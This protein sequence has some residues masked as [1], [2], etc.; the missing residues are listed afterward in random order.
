MMA[1]FVYTDVGA[2]PSALVAVSTEITAISAGPI[3]MPFAATW[4]WPAGAVRWIGV[5]A[6]TEL[7]TQG[8]IA[9][10]VANGIKF[11][12]DT[13]SDGPSDP[14]G[15]APSSANLE[16]VIWAEGYDGADR[17][18]RISI[19]GD[20]SGH[21]FAL[22]AHYEKFTL[23][24]PSAP[25]SGSSVSVSSLA[26]YA[27]SAI[28]VNAHGAIYHDDGAAF[29]PAGATLIAVTNEVAAFAANAW[30]TLSFPGLVTLTPGTYWLAI[31]PETDG[32]TTNVT[33]YN[34]ILSSAGGV[35]TDPGYYTWAPVVSAL[36]KLLKM[37]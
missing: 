18:G 3:A 17:L 7:D 26:V 34:G 27:T 33:L 13:Y 28:T 4:I 35:Q 21:Y 9:A 30:T 29:T 2:L 14:F 24:G 16:Y 6:D 15:G 36:L 11:N 25:V 23:G 8:S 12:A 10:V 31:I 20:P 32:P 1:F 5:I 37:T 22:D 19:G